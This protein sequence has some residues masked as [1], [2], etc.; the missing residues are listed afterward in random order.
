ME[1]FTN[2][3]KSI[4]VFLGSSILFG[5]LL[6]LVIIVILFSGWVGL[7]FIEDIMEDSDYHSK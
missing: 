7:G 4:F 2:R 6:L 1:N 5:F 3:F